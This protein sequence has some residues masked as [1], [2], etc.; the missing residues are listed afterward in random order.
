MEVTLT[1]ML[2]ARER[3]ARRQREL[4]ERFGKTVISFTMNIAG[5][6]KNSPE[7]ARGF[8]LGRELL[9]RQ[10]MTVKALP[11]Y[12]TEIRE[13]TGNEGLYVLELEP[14]E[15]KRLTVALEN[16]T[17]LGRLLDMDV[18]RPDGSKTE[19]GELG[20]PPRRC[21]I[22]G[23]P[24]QV[25]AR[26]RAHGLGQLQARTAELLEEALSAYDRETVARLACQALL[27][28]VCT[29]PKPGLVDRENSGSHRD[30][31][32]FTF[33]AS[34]AALWP[35]FARCAEIGRETRRA[36]PRET[37]RRLRT[38]GRL[39]EGDMLRATAG[40]NTHKGA[41][42]SMGLVCGALGRLERASWRQPEVVLAE[43]AAMAQ[44][45][46]EGDFRGMRTAQTPGE[47]LYVRYGISGVRG[48]AQAG[49]PA[50]LTGLSKL[51]TGLNRGLSFND[52]GCAALLAM[53]ATN[54]DTN[55]IARSS[56]E[57][58]QK[59]ARETAALLER[60]P[61]PGHEVLRALDRAF[62]AEN[63]SPGGT[64]DLL[65]LVYLLWLL[66]RGEY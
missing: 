3:R 4:L 31:D 35:Y 27:H 10:L 65:A 16:G 47:R 53:L 44:G 1:Q 29:T 54:P 45:I 50:V 66:K 64:A 33:Q 38:A 17:A 26:S 48:E 43:C 37:F 63:I 34:A 20:L 9:Y 18:L 55:V 41:I 14:M 49:F 2:E 24:A 39:A 8:D 60:E 13:E 25:C 23:G 57:T 22:C 51:E 58:Q 12:E 21:L 52:A 46:V 7:I 30:M 56:L 15:A 28:E 40:V 5:P 11:I 59:I 62:Q 42:F 36:L 6:V 19:R 32:I 61:F